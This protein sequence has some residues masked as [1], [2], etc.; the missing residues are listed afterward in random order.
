MFIQVG[1]LIQAPIKDSAR[2]FKVQID[3]LILCL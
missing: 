3:S 2:R 1:M